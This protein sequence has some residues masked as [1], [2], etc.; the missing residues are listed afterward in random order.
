[1]VDEKLRGISLVCHENFQQTL[2]SLLFIERTSPRAGKLNFP[3]EAA[4]AGRALW[5]KAYYILVNWMNSS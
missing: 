2:S 4:L 5:C 3:K 1:M